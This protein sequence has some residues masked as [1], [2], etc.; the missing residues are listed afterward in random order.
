[1]KSYD[2]EGPCSEELGKDFDKD[3]HIRLSRELLNE[4]NYW[5]GDMIPG[6]KGF[7][8]EITHSDGGLYDGE[9]ERTGHVLVREGKVIDFMSY[10][11]RPCKI[12]N[13]VNLSARTRAEHIA[14]NIEEILKK[15]KDKIA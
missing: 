15:G 13:I 4:T 14:R 3:A 6:D 11:I 12:E 1:M 10:N 7:C 2:F 9:T 5:G 8:Y